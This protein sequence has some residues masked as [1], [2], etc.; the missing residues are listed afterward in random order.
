MDHTNWQRTRDILI[1]I[2]GIGIVLWALW[3]VAGRFVDIIVILLLS[4]AVAFLL[5]PLVN[6]LTRY[7]V[8]RVVSTLIVFFYY[9]CSNRRAWF[10]AG[11]VTHSANSSVFKYCHIIL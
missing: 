8:P 10:R 11:P 2:I 5:T 6:F 3:I 9:N 4:L 7:S 1:S